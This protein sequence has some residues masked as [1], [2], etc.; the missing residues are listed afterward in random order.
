MEFRRVCCDVAFYCRDGLT[1]A[2]RWEIV[3]V[4]SVD[5]LPYSDSSTS[6]KNNGKNNNAY[7]Y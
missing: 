2:A 5:E 6:N 1:G 7:I 3:E 4:A